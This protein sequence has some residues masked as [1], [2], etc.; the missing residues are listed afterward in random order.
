MKKEDST[1]TPT[2]YQTLK[3]MLERSGLSFVEGYGNTRIE[4]NQGGHVHDSV[5]QCIFDKKGNLL[6]VF[7]RY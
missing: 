5:V 4:I 1:P 2:D 3:E 6:N 7:A